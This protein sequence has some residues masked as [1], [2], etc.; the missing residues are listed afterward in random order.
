MSLNKE[1][2]TPAEA[3]SYLSDKDDWLDLV[4]SVKENRIARASVY[5]QTNWTCENIDWSDSST[6]PEIVKESCAYYAYADFRGN[7]FSELSSDG[8]PLG[9][10]TE[11]TK[12]LDGL[13]TTTKYSDK[14]GSVS[15]N[16]LSYPDALMGT[17]CKEVFSGSVELIRV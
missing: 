14:T 16:P 6:I 3:D 11:L 15:P 10:I 5:L 4:D 7:L 12:D 13:L 8:T 1:V 17:E 2:I 9:R